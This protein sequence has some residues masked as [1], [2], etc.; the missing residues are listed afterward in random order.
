MYFNFVLFM[1]L[2]IVFALVLVTTVYF[3]LREQVCVIARLLSLITRTS[4]NSNSN[5]KFYL[6]RRYSPWT[7]KPWSG[8]AHGRGRPMENWTWVTMGRPWTDHGLTMERPWTDHK[9]TVD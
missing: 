2:N 4:I 8:L 6:C 7:S 9:L 5:L 3:V 1:Y